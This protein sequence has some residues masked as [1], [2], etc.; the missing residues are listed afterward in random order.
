RRFVRWLLREQVFDRR[1]SLVLIVLGALQWTITPAGLA[2]LFPL[3]A[4]LAFLGVAA[5]ETDPRKN[6][7]KRL[8][9]T[10]RA[11]RIYGIALALI[12]V[13]G[14][15]LAIVTDWVVVWLIPVQLTPL[16]LVAANLILAPFEER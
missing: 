10:A 15:A 5:L 3:L 12:A 13:L 6:A 16:A 2:W 7:K 4:G 9:M 11:K 1:L 8:V 14:A